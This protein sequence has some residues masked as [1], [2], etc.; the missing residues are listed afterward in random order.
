MEDKLTTIAYH[1]YSR[2]L[3]LQ[4]QLE[5]AGIECFLSNVN[6]IPALSGWRCEA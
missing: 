1:T 6:N 2:A 4:S 3:L 5:A